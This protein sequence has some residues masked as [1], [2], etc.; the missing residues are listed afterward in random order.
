MAGASVSGPA[1][2]FGTI[3][4]AATTVGEEKDLELMADTVK[5]LKEEIADIIDDE[6]CFKQWNNGN[7]SS[8]KMSIV[9][10]CFINN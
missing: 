6:G 2:G 5:L 10:I 1:L 3:P 7:S 4:Y 9:Y 8:Y